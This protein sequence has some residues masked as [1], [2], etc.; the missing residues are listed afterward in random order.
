MEERRKVILDCDT[1]CDDALAIMLAI[2]SEKIELLGVCTVAGN[3]T[4]EFTTENSLAV[5][6]ALGADVP[7]YRGCSSSMVTGLLPSRHGSYN[8]MTRNGETK[9]GEVLSYHSDHLPL[10]APTRKEEKEHAV[11]WLI[12]T[13]MKSDGDITIIP[14]GPMT[15]LAMAM[16]IEPRIC[17][18]IREIVFMGGG[19]KVFNAT[20]A[21]EF[22]VWTDPEA[23]QIVMTSG[24]KIT[25]VPLDATHSANFGF[26]EAKR[27]R[28]IGSVCSVA[29]A[30]MLEMRIETYDAYQPQEELHTAPLHDALAVSYIIDPAVLS[31]LRFMRVDVDI[32]GGFADGQTI[33]DT[34]AYPDRPRNVNVALCADRRRF[35]ELTMKL[36][37]RT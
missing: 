33:C 16:R 30:Q 22:N 25:M 19:F 6:E 34:R 3:K 4:I 17:S 28:D 26:T 35:I 8:G 11:F 37:A 36:L 23:A 10:P 21:A 2:L 13:L 29:V 18:K 12:D 15:N 7:V 27:L 24:V 9:N 31:E 5:V 32:S 14:T 20:C 1:G